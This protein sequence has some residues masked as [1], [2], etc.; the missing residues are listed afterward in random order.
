MYPIIAKFGPVTIYSYGLLVA[1]AFLFGIFIARLEARRKNIKPDLL[2]DLSLYLIIGSLLGG[3]LYYLIFFNPQVFIKAPI[4]ILKVW[5]GG[6]AIHGAVFGGIVAGL[7]FSKIHKASFW[8]LADIVAPS[9]ILGQA[10]GRI[11]CFLNSCCFG[12]PTE[13]MFGVKFPKGTL[14]D[15]AYNGLAVHPTQ[16]YE[17]FFSMIGF[18]V[19]WSA[20]KK[21]KFDGGLFLL[22]LMMY[23]CIRIFVSSLRGDSLYIWDTNIKIAQIVSGMI[24]IAALCLF[25]KRRKL[26]VGC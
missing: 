1:I 22:Y 5:K 23:N 8:K 18:F 14:P 24:F 2:Y 17:L 21:I 19:L 12:V 20:R 16:L 4:S 26:G 7:L 13:S 6:L 15:L 9:I 10:I 3:R 25:V 11:G